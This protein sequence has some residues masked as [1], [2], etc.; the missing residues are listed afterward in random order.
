[1]LVACNQ[2]TQRKYKN[3]DRE[4]HSWTKNIVPKALYFIRP[5][6]CRFLLKIFTEHGK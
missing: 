1:M 2:D 6:N 3:M 4:R 5:I